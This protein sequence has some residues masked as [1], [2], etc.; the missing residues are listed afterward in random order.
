M[1]KWII[2]YLFLGGSWSV[3]TSSARNHSKT[4][5]AGLK[6]DRS[7]KKSMTYSE[8]ISNESYNSYQNGAVPDLNS[9]SFKKE[10]EDFF[11][12]VQRENANRREDL[13][14]SQGGKYAGF[15]NTV[16]PPP[17]SYSTNDFY[18]T[19]MNGLTNVSRKALGVL[20]G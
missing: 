13:P 8:N 16:D 9:A 6:S 14:P 18:D 12:R 4:S 5:S 17:R 15:G 3:E 7:M 20:S 1:R 10:K 19:S 2:E 11:G